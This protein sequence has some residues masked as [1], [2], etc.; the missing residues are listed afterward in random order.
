MHYS[1]LKVTL[2]TIN[3]VKICTLDYIKYLFYFILFSK[4]VVWRLCEMWHSCV[5]Y[6]ICL[7]FTHE[8]S[9]LPRGW[10]ISYSWQLNI[11]IIF[12]IPLEYVTQ[13]LWSWTQQW[14]C[15]T[16]KRSPKINNIHLSCAYFLSLLTNSIAYLIHVYP[17]N[18]LHT[19]TI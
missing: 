14:N 19:H 1:K 17:P 15:F 5:T 4:I 8:P 13:D 11:G 12:L 7:K 10:S 9:F 6:E 18:Y 16:H 2:N 3:N